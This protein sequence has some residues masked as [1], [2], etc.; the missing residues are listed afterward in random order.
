MKYPK[1]LVSGKDINLSKYN[2]G[3]IRQPR[4]DDFMDDYDLQDFIKSFYIE[5][6]WRVNGVFD[7]KDLP[8]TFFMIACGQ[9]AEI[10]ESL[11][12]SLVLLYQTE[13]FVISPTGDNILIKKDKKPHAFI[14][15]SNFD[16]LCEVVLEMCKYNKPKAEK[17]EVVENPDKEIME[18]FE[19]HKKKKEEKDKKEATYFEEQVREVIH[20]RKCSYNDVKDWTVFQLLDAYVTYNYIESN[21]LSLQSLITHGGDAKKIKS[22]ADETKIKRD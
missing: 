13:D 3:I 16:Y 5:Q 6:S 12:K 2:L 15:N 20:M 22:W 18:L 1:Q 11:I 17:K 10:G 8:F 21:N 14:D 9:N 4:V 7:D 19:K